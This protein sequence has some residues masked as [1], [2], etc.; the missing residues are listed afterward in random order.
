[1]W[2]RAEQGQRGERGGCRRCLED[3]GE[4]TQKWDKD[5]GGRRVATK[6]RG[7]GACSCAVGIHKQPRSGRGR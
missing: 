4:K 2:S 7:P 6:G 5:P 3:S 1:M